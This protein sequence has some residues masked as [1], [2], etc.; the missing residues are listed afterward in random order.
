MCCR[1]VI[2]GTVNR[3]RSRAD[4]HLWLPGSCSRSQFSRITALQDVL[5]VSPTATTSPPL[6]AV[7]PENPTPLGV[8]TR[9]QLAP[10]HCSAKPLPTAQMFIAETAAIPV[11]R[12]LRWFAGNG[13]TV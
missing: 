4:G 13:F 9:L 1:S 2:F 10:F 8:L 7:I 5:H 12:Q 11:N 6:S 3:T